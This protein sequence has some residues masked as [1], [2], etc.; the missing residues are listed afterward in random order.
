MPRTDN[1]RHGMSSSS[2]KYAE[3]SAV[4]LRK[5]CELLEAQI[6]KRAETE[7]VPKNPM[8]KG[9]IAEALVKYSLLRRG[10]RVLDSSQDSSFDLLVE[11]S[12]RFLKCEVKGTTAQTVSVGKTSWVSGSGMKKTGYSEE[13]N[14]G[15]FFLVDLVRELI[16]VVPGIEVGFSRREITLSSRGAFWKYLDAFNLLEEEFRFES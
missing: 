9:L 2:V 10:F 6:R 12:K 7:V 5:R 3:Y 15:F 13:D 4:Q 1:L 16:F 14:I 11:S 8:T